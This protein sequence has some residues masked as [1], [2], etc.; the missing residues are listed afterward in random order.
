M[1][2]G[3]SLNR[4]EK[5]SG[6]EK[7]KYDEKSFL[8]FLRP[9]FFLACLDFFPPPLTAPGSPGMGATVTVAAAAV[10]SAVAAAAAATASYYLLL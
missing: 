3:K 5:K 10:S 8:T 1:G 2:A 4:R 7:V 6:E 9:N